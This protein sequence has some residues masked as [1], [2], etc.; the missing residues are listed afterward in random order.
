MTDKDNNERWTGR[1]LQLIIKSGQGIQERQEEDVTP[2]HQEMRQ[3]EVEC[4]CA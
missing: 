3:I 2:Q 4:S 1:R